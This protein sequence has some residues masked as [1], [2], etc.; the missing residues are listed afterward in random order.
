M[1]STEELP[2]GRTNCG[3]N[4]KKNIVSL[5]FNT[6]ISTAVR[7]TF[8]FEIVAGSSDWIVNGVLSRQ[9][10]GP[11]PTAAPPP[12]ENDSVRAVMSPSASLSLTAGASIQASMTISGYSATP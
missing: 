8:Q 4:A 10:H 7:M 11:E 12:A 1:C 6:L 3:K 9:T 5:G 2:P